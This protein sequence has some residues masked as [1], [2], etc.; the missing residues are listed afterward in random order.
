M[1]W[2]QAGAQSVQ[3][4]IAAALDLSGFGA[5]AANASNLF[6][7]RPPAAAAAAAGASTAVDVATGPP[8]ERLPADAA[9]ALQA[10]L[11]T[12]HDAGSSQRRLTASPLPPD[13]LQVRGCLYIA[14]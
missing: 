8:Y 12:W 3:A 9:E 4:S 2:A 1:S 13:A 10:V 14:R 6:A 11:P 5:A 7:L